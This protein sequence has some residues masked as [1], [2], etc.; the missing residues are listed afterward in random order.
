MHIPIVC[1]LN[2]ADSEEQEDQQE[3]QYDHKSDGD[4]RGKVR[5]DSS[6]CFSSFH[7]KSLH[8]AVVIF[9]ALTHVRRWITVTQ[10][11]FLVIVN[12]H[13]W[14]DIIVICIQHSVCNFGEVQRH[15]IYPNF[16][17]VTTHNYVSDFRLCVSIPVNWVTRHTK[18]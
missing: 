1:V 3:D 4:M 7:S 12:C 16:T 5:K 6:C 8:H 18:T 14:I 2:A 9:A 13:C 11:W 17:H 15:T 10:S